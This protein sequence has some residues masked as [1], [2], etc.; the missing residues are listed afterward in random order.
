MNIFLN[1]IGK[2]T[3]LFVLLLGLSVVAI[4]QEKLRDALDTDGDD[5]A[6]FSVF[7][8]SNNVW[9]ILGSGGGFN[10]QQ[11]GLA[12]SD[13]MSPG[14]FDGDG[15]GDI[16]VWR[17]SNGGW[18]WLSS[19]DSTFHAIGFGIS[20][21]EPVGRDYDGDGKTD[22][23][24]VR[25]TGGN[26]IWYILGSTAGFTTQQFGFS[27]DFT[28][29]GDYDGDG[30]FDLAIQRPGALA[31]DPATFYIQRSS[32]S[33]VTAQT[34]GFSTDLVVPG[35][36]D[37]DGKTD[38][39][40]VREGDVNFPNNLIW[41]IQRSSDLGLSAHVFGNI[42]T[43]LNTQNDYDGDGKTDLSIWRNSDGSY[44]ILRSSDSNLQVS[45]WGQAQDFPIAS[46]D[47]H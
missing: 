11:F 31:N 27:T 21:D 7:R 3:L 18:Y 9:Y 41:Y 15:K 12:N 16:A 34:W 2:S 26:M 36:Y 40:V 13:Y 30:S 20:G 43:D 35:D 19:L 42:S 24:V 14:D 46:Y 23:A 47:T 5:K 17:D 44:Y 25:R 38:I 32:D 6:D 1:K 8:P 22:P 4:S 28:A 33:G 29:P 37:G 39:A 45:Q 10:F